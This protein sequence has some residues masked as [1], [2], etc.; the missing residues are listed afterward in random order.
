MGIQ[1]LNYNPYI[2]TDT[3]LIQLRGGPFK[4]CSSWTVNTY[5]IISLFDNLIVGK[6]KYTC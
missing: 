6:L 5:V 1:Y 4:P 2:P 3:A